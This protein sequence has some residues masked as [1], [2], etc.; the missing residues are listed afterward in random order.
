MP[1]ADVWIQGHTFEIVGTTDE[2][3]DLPTPFAMGINRDSQYIPAKGDTA[4]FYNG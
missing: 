2:E 1:S 3:E 4:D